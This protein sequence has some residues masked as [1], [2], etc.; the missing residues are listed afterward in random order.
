MFIEKI[1]VAT[2]GSDLA[3]RAAQMA[4][5]LAK[6]GG[7]RILAF[8]VAQPRTSAATDGEPGAGAD[9]ET[10]GALKAAEAR[11][12]TIARIARAGG[13]SCEVATALAGAAGP[14]IVRAA[15]DH[16]CDLI[17]V[18]VHSPHD[19]HRHRQG[20]GSTAQHLLAWSSIPV[21]VYRDPREASTPE[22]R[23]GDA[24]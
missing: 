11:V 5:L 22:F 4:V 19:R 7:G 24:P 2:D 21:L 10:G 1:C 14:E 16:G 8:S 20:T 15:E 17:I 9:S 18:G 23:D 3:S 6:S 13:V 12:A